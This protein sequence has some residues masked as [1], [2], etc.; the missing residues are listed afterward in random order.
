MIDEMKIRLGIDAQKEIEIWV[1]QK[2]NKE[3]NTAIH[4][5][6]YVGNIDIIERLIKLWKLVSKIT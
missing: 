4:Y 3:G 5:A 2:T 1:N 6:S